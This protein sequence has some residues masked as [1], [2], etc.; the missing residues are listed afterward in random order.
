MYWICANG[1]EVRKGEVINDHIYH[2]T[3]KFKAK[4][5]IIK[6]N[7]VNKKI[8]RVEYVNEHHAYDKNN[9]AYANVGT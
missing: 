7:N 2:R 6:M 9:A 4:N 8:W 1:E 3:I 5:D